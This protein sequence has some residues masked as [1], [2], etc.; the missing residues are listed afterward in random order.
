MGGQAARVRT[1][2]RRW[3]ATISVVLL[4]LVVVLCRVAAAQ[5]LVENGTFERV[6]ARTGVPQ[7]W[8]A[9]GNP[10]IAQSLRSVSDPQRGLVAQLSCT[11]FSGG[12]PD[13]HVM[14]AQNGRVGVRR[15]QWYRLGFWA[16]AADLRGRSVQVALVDRRAWEQVGLRQQFLPAPGWQHH[17]FTFRASQDLPPEHSR[18]Q[19]WFTGTGTLL[20]DDVIME[21][22]DPVQRQWRPALLPSG[23]GNALPNSSFECGGSGWGCWS[24]GISGWGGQVF[25][26]MGELDE[27]QAFHGRRSWKLSLSPDAL[28]VIYWD[29]Y[30]PLEARI[31]TLL[32]GH[33]GWV[34]VERGR[35]YTFSAYCRTDRDDLPVRMAIV[36]ADGRTHQRTFRVSTEWQRVEMAFKADRDFASGFVGLD[37]SET[38]PPEGTV[39]LDA[40]QWE[41]GDAATPYRPRTELESMIA[42]P[43]EGS[44]LT[45]PGEG[46]A[47]DLGAHNGGQ[48]VGTVRGT[49][50][51]TDFLD[52]IAWQQKVELPVPAGATE[53]SRFVGILPGRRGWF[54][55]RWQPEGGAPQDVRYAVID[56]YTED[57]SVFGMNHAYP[58]EFLLRLSHLAGLRWWR[59]WSVKWQTVQPEPDGFDFRVPDA[60]VDR[61]LDADGRVLVLL[62]FP[63]AVWATVPDE[64]KIEERAAGNRS[65]A[66]RL[67][68]AFK[69]TRLDDFERYVRESVAHYGDRIRCFEILNEPLFTHYAVPARFGYGIDDYIDLLRT[70]Y[71][72]AKAADPDCFVIGGI[73]A[74]PS[75]KWAKAF[76]EA[77]GPQWCDAVNYHMY[78]RADWPE[79]HEAEIRAHREL[80]LERGFDKPIWW[81][82]LGLY[83]DDDPAFMPFK[84]G[85]DAM[86]GAMRPSELAA[87][88]DLVRFAAILCAHGTRKIFYHAGTCAALNQSS[89]GNMFFRYGG[90]PYKQFAAQAALSQLLGPDLEFVG[91]WTE[92]DWLTAYE[93]RSR[94]RTVVVAWT[95]SEDA[96]PLEL[97]SDLTALDMMGN[98]LPG[99]GI[100]IGDIPVYFVGD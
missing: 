45:R 83:A 43:A 76:L 1:R 35:S 54:R 61:V 69:P 18:L 71:G 25:R 49:L 89:A 81:T 93:F 87:A 47:F 88:A 86:S 90:Q 17:T 92:P 14:L 20:V 10:A 30:E 57:D 2:E 12:E 91:K 46:F 72:A 58:W 21:T 27:S 33:E 96:P 51:V 55:L 59:D 34:A 62:P 5:T 48:T 95:R 44:I 64:E 66:E 13:S 28:P 94:G 63:S 100:R 16:R 11:R 73:A 31:R 22:T 70:A 67:P 98:P 52:E 23:V 9:S 53:T 40:L 26:R 8:A 74:P 7:A 39:W 56:P 3:A 68:T 19:V 29:Y 84:V 37:L 41:E 6:D 85:D 65:M 80:M 97:R 24:P 75:N 60:Q 79:T 99:R 78:P 4:V 32:L 38:D 82:E 42:A 36:Q 15:G 50:T 77:D